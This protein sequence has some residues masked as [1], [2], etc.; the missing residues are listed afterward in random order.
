MEGGCGGLVGRDLY[1]L[2]VMQG[3]VLGNGAED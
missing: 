2:F 3:G 1:F